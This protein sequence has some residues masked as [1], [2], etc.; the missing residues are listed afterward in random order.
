MM[1]PS[2]LSPGPTTGLQLVTFRLS[3]VDLAVP[4]GSVATIRRASAVDPCAASGDGDPTDQ[5]RALVA[6]PGPRGHLASVLEVRTCAGPVRLRA[7][8]IVE[9]TE[10]VVRRGAGLPAWAMGRAQIGR[11]DVVVI[12]PDRLRG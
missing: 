7:D 2:A 11:R 4:L 12:E 10:S 1:S 9:V 3:G 8:E 6:G 5:V